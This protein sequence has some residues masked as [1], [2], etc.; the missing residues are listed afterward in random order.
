LNPMLSAIRKMT[1]RSISSLDF[2]S[3]AVWG[4][5]LAWP[6]PHISCHH[7]VARKSPLG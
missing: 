2:G 3:V 7:L 6:C 4:E 1:H 5:G